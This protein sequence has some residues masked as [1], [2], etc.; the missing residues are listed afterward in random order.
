MA[1][2]AIAKTSTPDS[3]LGNPVGVFTADAGAGTA[4]FQGVVTVDANTGLPPAGGAPVAVQNFPAT[5]PA[6]V[7]D[8]SDVNAGAK[9][10][11]AVTSDVSGS[12]SAKLRGLVKILADVWDSVN[13][14]LNVFIQNATL[15]VTQSGSWT[16]TTTPPANASEN[17]NQIGGTAIVTS[18]AGSQGVGGDTADGSADAGK[19]VKVGGKVTLNTGSLPT[20]LSANQRGPV[21]V[22]EYGRLRVVANRP[23]LLGAY[24]FESGIL[25][26]AAAAHGST[27]GF[28]W[29]INPAGSSV[30]MYVKKLIAT[31]WPTAA[32]AFV[33]SPRVTIERMTF[34]GTPSGATITPAK[35]D[36]NDAANTGTVRTASTGMTITAGAIVSDFSV[37]AVLTAVGIHPPVD[38]YMYDDTDDDDYIV[39]RPGEGLVA[40]QA[41]AGSTS[42]TRKIAIYGSWE[43]R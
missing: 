40:R 32:T 26:I 29:L 23:K 14:R 4:D 25:S 3:S 11:A 9:A 19:S 34:T 31:S 38:Q 30:V 27:A 35:R 22:D 5:Q 41:D 12:L 17:L 36:S 16:V 24:K 8:G 1:T 18:I 28:F 15:A 2:P 37:P 13:H 6:S 42:D 10:D 33:T 39:L 21:M 43:E 20:A 7:A